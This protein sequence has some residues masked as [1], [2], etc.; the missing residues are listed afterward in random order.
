M[1]FY[2]HPE[3]Y[4]VLL[5]PDPDIFADAD[6][7]IGRHLDGPARRVLDPACGPGNW[8]VRFAERGAAVAGNDLEPAMIAAARRRLAGRPAELTVGDMADLDFRT[9]PFDVAINV[10]SSVGHL[11]DDAAVVRHLR[12]VAR[13]LRPG[14]IYLLGLVIDDGT[15]LREEPEFLWQCPAT[16]IPGGG[17]AAVR[18][19]SARRDPAARTERI[20]LHLLTKGVA[21]CPEALREEYDLRT[22]PAARLREILAEAGGFDVLAA[23]AMLVEGRPDVGLVHDAGDVTLVLRRGE[24]PVA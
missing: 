14:G 5:E 9:G 7:W 20:R 4:A 23:H 17:M 16:R 12:A 24:D 8:L 3:V 13:H 19:E 11:P 15:A 1:S 22:F 18:Y 21:G 10:H 6:A 2:R